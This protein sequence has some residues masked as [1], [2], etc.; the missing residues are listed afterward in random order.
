MSFL[1]KEERAKRALEARAK[2]VEAQKEREAAERAQK[3]AFL[4]QV[5][6]ADKSL[7]ASWRDDRVT[8]DDDRRRN[9]NSR[10][11]PRGDSR[12][13][14]SARS[15]PSETRLKRQ[16]IPEDEA[17]KVSNGQHLKEEDM[18]SIRVLHIL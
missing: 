15:G 9:Y 12:R 6:V 10:D 11:D 1:S 2:E 7:R 3:L 4:S 16:A 5:P 13:R 18:Q 14:D 17:L 8:M